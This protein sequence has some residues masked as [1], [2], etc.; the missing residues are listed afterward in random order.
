MYTEFSLG[1]LEGKRQHRKVGVVRIILKWYLKEED[2]G[3]WK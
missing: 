3:M 1:N 2:R